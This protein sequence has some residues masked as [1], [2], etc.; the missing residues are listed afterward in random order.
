VELI[1]PPPHFVWGLN[2]T[3]CPSKGAW[4]FS[5]LRQKGGAPPNARKLFFPP[6]RRFGRIFTPPFKQGAPLFKRGLK[7]PLK[8]LKDHSFVEISQ[9]F[10]K[11]GGKKKN[12]VFQPKKEKGEKTHREDSKKEFTPSPS[13]G[14]EKPIF[15]KKEFKEGFFPKP[16]SQG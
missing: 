5:P 15:L 3:L 14:H 12:R 13:C 7:N 4:L 1:H 2:Q 9:R 6:P 11:K 10:P 16:G 8:G